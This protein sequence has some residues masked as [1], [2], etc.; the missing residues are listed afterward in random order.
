MIQKFAKFLNDLS[1]GRLEK[2]ETIANTYYNIR[3]KTDKTTI[4]ESIKKYNI[5]G[6]SMYL[7]SGISHQSSIINGTHEP[8]VTELLRSRLDSSTVFYDIGAHIGYYTLLCA[9]NSDYVVSAEPDP[10]AYNRLH[11]NI[12]LNDFGN[13]TCLNKGVFDEV[14]EMS[15]HKHTGEEQASNSFASSPSLKGGKIDVPVTTVD[16]IS[17]EYRPPDLVKIDVEGAELRVLN[18]MVETIS[19][20]PELI[21]EIHSSNNNRY[22]KISK[23]GDSVDSLI[24]FLQSYEYELYEIRK[25]GE[26]HMISTASED[27]NNI[28]AK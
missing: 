11:K 10:D 19:E 17:R 9:A 21:V 24:E 7:D 13:I 12:E 1:G 16:N 4:G 23:F 14:G 15:L 2:S 26:L 20:K 28:F 5:D 27:I 3:K 22:D 6:F 8:G 25:S 18:G